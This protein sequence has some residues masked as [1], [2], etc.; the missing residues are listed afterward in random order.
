MSNSRDVALVATFAALSFVYSVSIGQLPGL[1]TGNAGMSYILTIF[2]SIIQSVAYLMYEGRR[3][4]I[5]AQTLILN[6][7]FFLFI[8]NWTLLVTMATIT[9][10]FIVDVIFN[11]LYGSWKKGNRLFRWILTL[12]LFLWTTNT[13]LNLL[14][15]PLIMPME[16]V[17][18]VGVPFMLAMLPLI[19]IEAIAGSY[20]GYKIYK[21]VAKISE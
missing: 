21:R 5:L 20:I 19:I 10:M 13:F 17:I 11:S 8:P 18:G 1:I 15:F 3:W 4:R 9:N 7:L 12:Q 2:P 16:M 14:T 6:L